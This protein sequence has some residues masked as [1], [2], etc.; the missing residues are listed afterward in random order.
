MLYDL[1]PAT[2]GA[3]EVLRAAGVTER[4]AI[5]NGSFFDSVPPG[6]DVYVLKNIIHDWPDE[7][8]LTIL[9]AVRAALRPDGRLQ[10][11]E[12]L[13]PEQ[14][15]TSH[16]SLT[17]DLHVLLTIGGRERTATE[18]RALLGAAGFGAA[19]IIATAAPLSIIEAAPA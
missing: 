2:A 12:C 7:S 13:I 14:R 3:P 19:R 6:A 9:R 8:A 10:L 18:Y 11:I 16:L 15:N 17:L 4:C 5:E 1:A